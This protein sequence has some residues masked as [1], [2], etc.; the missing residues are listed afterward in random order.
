MLKRIDR[1]HHGRESLLNVEASVAAGQVL[2]G[3]PL[4]G[5]RASYR[6]SARPRECA[7]PRQIPSATV[8]A[9]TS[10]LGPASLGA[11]E[12]TIASLVAGVVGTSVSR[13]T[14][15]MEAGLDS[16]ASSELVKEVG[17]EFSAELSATLLFDHPSIA[18]LSRHVGQELSASWPGSGDSVPEGAIFRRL[19]ESDFTLTLET[20]TPSL[21]A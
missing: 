14:P 8:E 13:D 20:G 19:E 11:V 6:Q 10:H 18:A 7:V 2:L 3:I 1:H 12:G 17:G 15:L 9:F 16:L 5:R 21:A 4:R